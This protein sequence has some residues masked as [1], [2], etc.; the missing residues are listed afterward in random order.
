MEVKAFFEY[1]A[2]R[3]PGALQD[4]HLST[5]QRRVK[6]W[7]LAQGPDKEVFFPQ[8]WEVGRALQLEWTNANALA[9]TIAR[10][11]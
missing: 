9:I 10:R 5:F 1:L 7:L 3:S 2:E 11:P 4:Q 6:L 8:N